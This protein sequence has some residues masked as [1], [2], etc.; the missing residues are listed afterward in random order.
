MK[1][2]IVDMLPLDPQTGKGTRWR[3]I[4]CP[5]HEGGNW[6]RKHHHDFW[7]AWYHD[8]F[9]IE[10]VP[11]LPAPNKP[12]SKEPPGMPWWAWPVGLVVGIWLVV[13]VVVGML[14]EISSPPM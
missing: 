14:A 5:L 7:R 4:A 8:G 9:Q 12:E 1:E 2:K 10:P 3:V 6:G 11:A 13:L